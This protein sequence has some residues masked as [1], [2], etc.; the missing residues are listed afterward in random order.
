M[1]IGADRKQEEEGEIWKGG[2]GVERVSEREKQVVCRTL[3]VYLERQ[4]CG[5]RLF[6]V[7]LLNGGWQ[8]RQVSRE[9]RHSGFETLQSPTLSIPFPFAHHPATAS[10]LSS[11]SRQQLLN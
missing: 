8:M 10:M 1:A 2:V 3:V 5:E 4:R 6:A 11:V 9:T 7:R